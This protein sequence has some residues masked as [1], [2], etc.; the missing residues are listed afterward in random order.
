[1]KVFKF[2]GASVKDAAGLRNVGTIISSFHDK[3][4][5]IVVSAIGKT[6]N[7][8]EKIAVS[9]YEGG[10]YQEALQSLIAQHTGIAAELGLQN[11]FDFFGDMLVT[12]AGQNS[13]R[14]YPQFY[15]QIVS[16]GELM[17]SSLLSQYLLSAGIANTRI[18]AREIIKT[19]NSWRE[20]QVNW[21][22]TLKAVQNTLPA[23]LKSG[24]VVTQGFIGGAPDGFTTTLGRE[25]SDYTAAILAHCTNAEGQWIWK[26]VPGVLSADPKKYPDAVLLPE[27]TYYEAIE[28]TYYGAS[29]I[30]PKTIYPLQQKQIP[31]YVRSFL[32]PEESGTVIA[33]DN[34]FIP[35]PAVIMHK[36]GQT[37]ISITPSLT[38][39]VGDMQMANIYAIFSRHKL[40]INTIQIAAQSVSIVVDYDAYLL[41]SLMAD[42]KASYSKVGVRENTDLQLLTVRHYNEDLLKKLMG[43]KKVYLEQRSRSTVQFLFE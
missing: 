29:V 24:H 31:L 26:D 15:D 14:S 17:S 40:R 27:L 10:D 7:A 28:M 23:A 34:K 1:M 16:I 21:E 22:E 43:D 30:H 36:S 33:T 25:G 12:L 9:A 35:Y 20:G 4:I 5:V 3:D 13:H 2:G 19:D 38:T 32:H 39:F 42:L 6:T 8:L 11:G 37:L 41:E 18:D